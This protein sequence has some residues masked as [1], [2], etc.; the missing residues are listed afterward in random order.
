MIWAKWSL[1]LITIGSAIYCNVFFP[2]LVRTKVSDLLFTCS[3]D[4]IRWNF[5]FGSYIPRRR[6]ESV[7]PKYCEYP[8]RCSDWQT[9]THTPQNISFI[10]TG[11]VPAHN[12]RKEDYS[13]N[14]C[15]CRFSN[16]DGDKDAKLTDCSF[17]FCHYLLAIMFKN[18]FFDCFVLFFCGTQLQILKMFF[19]A[20]SQRSWKN[21][22]HHK[23]TMK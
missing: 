2:Q 6:L 22:T 14:N 20:S 7:I 13:A 3:D 15:N 5:W 12:P 17:I 8:H 16:T 21:K 19:K 9:D 11:A 18:C 4:N 23:S 10:R 1:D